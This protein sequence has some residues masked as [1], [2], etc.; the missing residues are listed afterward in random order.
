MRNAHPLLTV[1][2]KNILRTFEAEILKIFKIFK[3]KQELDLRFKKGL[4]GD[5]YSM[6]A[7]V[8]RAFHLHTFENSF[9][10]SSMPG[11]TPSKRRFAKRE[12][13]AT[14]FCVWLSKYDLNNLADF[15]LISQQDRF[16][17]NCAKSHL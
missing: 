9:D 13:L 10:K 16:I 11:G 17:N 15:P 4:T 3:P 5:I 12:P 7:N 1:M 2:L 14:H 6:V 8:G